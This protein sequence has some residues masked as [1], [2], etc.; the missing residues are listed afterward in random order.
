MTAEQVKQSFRERGLTFTDWAKNNGFDRNDVYRVLNGQIKAYR[1]TGHDIA[2][3]LG[4]KPDPA[5][6]KK[7]A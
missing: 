7:A 4:M 3:K 1:G 6:F 2:V 5:S